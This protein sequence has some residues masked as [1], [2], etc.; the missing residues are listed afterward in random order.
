[1]DFHFDMI[2]LAY[3]RTVDNTK[4]FSMSYMNKILESWKNAGFKNVEE[5]EK[6][7]IKPQASDNGDSFN[8]DDF[9]KAAVERNQ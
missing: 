2:K 5:V 1:M 4:S 3:D 8:L 7:D 6:G 9:F